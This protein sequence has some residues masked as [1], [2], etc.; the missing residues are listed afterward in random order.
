MAAERDADPSNNL[1]NTK[2]FVM[3]FVFVWSCRDHSWSGL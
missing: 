3:L 1:V 2:Q